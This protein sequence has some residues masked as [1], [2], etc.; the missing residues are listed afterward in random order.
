[1][2][3]IVVMQQTWHAGDALL[4]A[5]AGAATRMNTELTGLFIEDINLLNLAGMPFASEVCFPS[6]TRREMDVSRLENS[7]RALAGEAQRALEAI[8]RSTDLRSSFR[9]ARGHLLAELLAAASATDVV[10]AGALS[11]ISPLPELSVVCLAG[12]SRARIAALIEELA[13]WVRGRITIVVLETALDTARSWETEFRELLGSG[14]LQHRVRVLAPRN[15]Q[16]L[17]R[18]LRHPA[19][20]AA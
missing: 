8:A 14:T 10:V 11:R 6:A 20:Q 7:L 5:S 2:R 18:Q 12:V 15:Q 17:E 3:R 13:P 19:G 1:M 9:V 4:R 16:D